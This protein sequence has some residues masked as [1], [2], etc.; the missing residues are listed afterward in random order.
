[1]KSNQKIAKYIKD[2]R[3]AKNTEQLIKQVVAVLSH[4][5]L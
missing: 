4:L 2:V 3:K 5:N 1:M